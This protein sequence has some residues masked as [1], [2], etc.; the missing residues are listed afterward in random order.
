MGKE[1]MTDVKTAIKRILDVGLRV[2]ERS[3]GFS[4]EKGHGEHTIFGQ[5]GW[6]HDGSVSISFQSESGF[7]KRQPFLGHWFQ[8]FS[9]AEMADFLISVDVQSRETGASWWSCIQLQDSAYDYDFLEIRLRKK[10]PQLWEAIDAGASGDPMTLQ[11]PLTK[12][13]AKPEAD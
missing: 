2:K 3:Y 1:H 5:C 10:Y 7:G 6:E 12:F 9:M 4:I 8:R 13:L 11:D